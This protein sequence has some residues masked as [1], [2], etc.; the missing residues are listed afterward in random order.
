ML[1]NR[2]AVIIGAGHPDGMG[3]VFALEFAGQN[4]RCL[5]VHTLR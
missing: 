4:F 5:C 3:R 1:N 2:I